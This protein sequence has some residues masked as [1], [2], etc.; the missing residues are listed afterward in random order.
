MVSEPLV[1]AVMLTRDRPAMAARAVAAFRAQ[2]YAKKRLIVWDTGHVP[3]FS[4][5]AI[6]TEVAEGLFYVPEQ[7]GKTIGWLR[8]YIADCIHD[9]PPRPDIFVHWDDDDLSHPNRIAEQVALLQASGA[10]CVGFNE[11]LFWRKLD[12]EM[13]FDK[14]FGDGGFGAVTETADAIEIET[15]ALIESPGEAW[16][17]SNRNPLYATGAS[18]C[19]WRKTWERHPFKDTMVGEDNAFL[20]DIRDAGG[21]IVTVSCFHKR[22]FTPEGTEVGNCQPRLIQC[23]HGGNTAAQVDE[24]SDQWRRAPEWDNYA[25]GR[26]AL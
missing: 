3:T 6:V 5:K 24:K 8:N 23:I 2:T 22:N 13:E 25:R 4:A 16:I 26:M 21:N 10:D 15:G 12:G 1:C 7:R 19:Y 17:Y 14:N 18:L 20:Q 9:E 11:V